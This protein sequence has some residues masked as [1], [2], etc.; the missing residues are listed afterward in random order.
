MLLKYVD[1]PAIFGGDFNYTSDAQ[2]YRLISL[3]YSDCLVEGNTYGAKNNPYCEFLDKE[4][5]KIDYIFIDP[6]FQEIETKILFNGIN[7][8]FVSDHC[9]V[10]TRIK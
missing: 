10:F 6:K 7:G 3:R 9:G 8:P 2:A 5:Y 1:S 4:N